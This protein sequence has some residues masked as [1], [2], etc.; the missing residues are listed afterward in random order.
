MLYTYIYMCIYEYIRLDTYV[1]TYNHTNIYM[2]ICIGNQWPNKHVDGR[3]AGG[4][5]IYQVC[6]CVYKYMYICS[7][8]VMSIYMC[9][10]Y[11]SSC[12]YILCKYIY[13]FV[14][15]YIHYVSI[16]IFVY[17]YYSPPLITSGYGRVYPSYGLDRLRL[18]SAHNFLP[19]ILL[20]SQPLTPTPLS[21]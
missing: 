7:M 19:L 1:H 3:L 9:T 5:P 10:S 8:Y 6:I 17:A 13:T 16:N 20:T 11:I 18:F 4:R 14:Y 21:H 2:Y 12:I 15:M